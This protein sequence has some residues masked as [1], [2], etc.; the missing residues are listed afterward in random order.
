[1]GNRTVDVS[2][3]KIVVNESLLLIER[4]RCANQH[5][6]ALSVAKHLQ[7]FVAE[8]C[9]IHSDDFAKVYSCVR[10]LKIEL[11]CNENVHR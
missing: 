9:D 1:M 7:S 8:N 5:R 11:G 4:L 3:Y 2:T 6:F 10:R